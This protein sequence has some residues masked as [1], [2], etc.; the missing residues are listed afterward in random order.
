M[1][2]HKSKA[3]MN[4]RRFLRN[5]LAIGGGAAALTHTPFLNHLVHAQARN[6]D[7]PDRYYIFCYFGGGWDVLLSL[8]PRDPRDFPSTIDSMRSTQIQPGYETLARPDADIIRT[9]EGISFGPYIGDLAQH[10][11]RMAVVRGLN[12]E[13]LSHTGGRRRFLTGKAPTGTLARGSNASTWLAGHLGAD[14]LIPNLSLRVENY[15]RDLP[16]YAS[17]LRVSAVPDL[18]RALEP[19]QPSLEPLLARQV[20]EALKATSVCPNSLKSIAWQKAEF[21]RKSANQVVAN[22]LSSAF[23]FSAR[24]AEMERL[25]G[26][27]GF[28][29]V[30][31]SPGVSAAL[32]AQAITQRISRCVSVNLVGGLDTHAGTQWTQD[33]GPRQ[34]AGFNAVA[35]LIEDLAQRPYDDRSSW[36][37]H[38][39]I[40]GFSEFSRTPLLNLSGGR[41]HHL[42]NSCFLVGGSVRGGQVI[43]ASTDVGMLAGNVNLA[44]GLPSPDG[45]VIRPEHVLRSLYTE[46]GIGDEP[47][48]R[49]SELPT[50]LRT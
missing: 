12:M 20:D 25:R 15:N 50:L 44:T 11:G 24:N 42:V 13:T 49:V 38:T 10:A 9:P 23:Q 2:R 1:A 35:R 31:N 22:N 45:E 40:I 32:A 21:A 6:L 18:L 34:E 19:A 8:D 5:T 27:Y 46:V 48:L 30:G 33:Q 47:D 7:A 17:A 43:G 41:D 29:S 3:G 36:L 39:T 28:T 16:N 4:R 37:D 26:H 14:D